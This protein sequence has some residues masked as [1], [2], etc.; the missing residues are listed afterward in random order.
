LELGGGMGKILTFR[1]LETW[2]Q[3]RKLS[4]LIYE[5]TRLYPKEE[6]YCLVSQMRRAAVSVS[7]NIAEGFGRRTPKD[8]CRFYDMAS[9]SLAELQSQTYLSKD[10]QYIQQRD[11]EEV[12]RK[13]ETVARLIHGL[14]RSCNR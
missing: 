14:I 8:K 10:L 4:F 6:L 9:A 5:I 2:Q 7:S 3:A 13:T 11:F 12:F 1:D